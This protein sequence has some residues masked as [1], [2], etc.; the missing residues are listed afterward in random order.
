MKKALIALAATCMTLV[1]CTTKQQ[2]E[3]TDTKKT[4]VI[5]YSQTGTTKA[6]ADEICKHVDADLELIEAEVPYDGTYAETIER[7]QKEKAA[8]EQLGIK[9]LKSDISKYDTI[10][11]GTP[12]W[13]GTFATPIE[14]LVK[15]TDFAG[16]KLIPFCTFGSGG[17]N[18]ITEDLRKAQPN[19]TILE[20]YGVRTARISHAAKEVDYFLKKNGYVKGDVAELPDFT[21]QQPVTDE[22]KA[23][24]DAACGEYQFPLGTPVTVGSRDIDDGKEYK[25]TV[26]AKGR[27]GNESTSTIYVISYSEEGAKPEFTQVVR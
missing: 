15:S 10:Y 23:I 2:S 3:Q 20:G 6:V 21:E 18:A 25:Y 17:L 9:P 4:L 16:K 13:F 1:G 8:G 27:D 14:T 19:A 12:V 22:E 7:Y 5:C 11:L 24:F 26:T